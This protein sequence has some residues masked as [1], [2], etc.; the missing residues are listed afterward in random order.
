VRNSWPMLADGDRTARKGSDMDCLPGHN[1][2]ASAEVPRPPRRKA[3]S[4]IELLVVIA[5]IAVLL[6]ILVPTLSRVA[7]YVHRVSCMSKLSQ[8]QKA[9]WS[10]L[11][12]YDSVFPAHK[13]RGS[14][15]SADGSRPDFWATDLLKFTYTQELFRCPSIL[16]TEYIAGTPWEWNFGPHR[17]GYGY[18]CYFLG[19][20]SH[21]PDIDLTAQ[22][23]GWMSTE[24]W[25][26]LKDIKRPADCLL[27]ADT[28]PIPPGNWWASSMWWPKSGAP[29]WEG[30]N[31]MRHLDEGALVFCDGH[32]ETRLSKDINPG[33]SPK[34]TGDDYNIRFWDPRQR[35]NP[36]F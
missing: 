22:L 29:W 14:G 1:N 36:N 15:M 18:N 6:S 7:D 12:A 31:A 25:F 34:E 26:K 3:F 28:N 32:A 33:S 27:L 21:N 16:D 17:L 13:Q 4:L 10:Y 8:I 30:V 5:I 24:R 23:Q 11:A 19:L 9:F 2:S 20:Y 35:D